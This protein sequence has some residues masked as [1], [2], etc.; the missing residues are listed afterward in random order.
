MT[1]LQERFLETYDHKKLKQY[2]FKMG[3]KTFWYE[4]FVG[5]LGV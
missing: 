4:T 5:F 3:Q 2:T 1:Q